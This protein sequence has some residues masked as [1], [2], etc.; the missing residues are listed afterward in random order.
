MNDLE[1]AI[2]DL[3]RKILIKRRHELYQ[4]AIDNFLDAKN[5]NIY[6][7]LTENEAQEYEELCKK[8]DG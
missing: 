1:E 3:D 2:N 4:I 7:W 8:L 5:F 6:G